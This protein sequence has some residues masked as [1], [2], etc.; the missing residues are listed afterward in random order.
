MSSDPEKLASIQSEEQASSADSDP[1]L[2]ETGTSPV[3]APSFPDGGREAWTVCFFFLTQFF[4][5]P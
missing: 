3:Q 1:K 4:G 2:S 5:I